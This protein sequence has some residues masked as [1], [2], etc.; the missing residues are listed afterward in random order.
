MCRLARD[1][2]FILKR[3]SLE[4]V[5]AKLAQTSINIQKMPWVHQEHKQRATVK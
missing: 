4:K 3:I 2:L 1:R 5:E